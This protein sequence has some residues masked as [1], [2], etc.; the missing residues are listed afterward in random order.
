MCTERLPRLEGERLKDL[1]SSE[2]LLDR[3]GPLKLFGCTKCLRVSLAR[4]STE[5]DHP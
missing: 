4:V 1:L 3:P 5:F 2:K